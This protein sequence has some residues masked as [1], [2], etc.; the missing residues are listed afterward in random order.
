LSS[1]LAILRMKNYLSE[2]IGIIALVDFSQRSKQLYGRLRELIR[3]INSTEFLLIV[4]HADRNTP[5]DLALKKFFKDFRSKNIKLV[6]VIPKY[7]E[8]EL[9]RLRNE[10]MRVADVKVVLLV[11]VDIFP[12]LKLFRSLASSVFAGERLS[13]APCIYLSPLGN[14]I[15]DRPGG[16]LKVV[17]SALSF[18]PDFVMHWAI[19]SSVMAFRHDDYWS[20]GGFYEK[21]RGHG[22]EDF[23]FMLRLA[24][25]IN[26]IQP[27]SDLLI[28]RTYR[29]PLLS[30]GFRAVLGRLCLPNLLC[31]NIAV[32]LHHEKDP[33]SSYQL[34]R[35][36]NSN[37]F[38]NRIRKLNG[39][40]IS[41][42]PIRG[43]QNLIIDF[44]AECDKHG[45]DP[46]RFHVL[47]DS[48][49]RH[50]LIRRPWWSR[51]TRSLSR[52]FS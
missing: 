31:G 21:F 9:A 50:L 38:Q 34:R 47:F 14:K 52:F 41:N 20:V 39:P 16:I 42:A 30:T 27:S 15:I 22:Y 23:D 13:M 17:E 1:Y 24:M 3:V 29:A 18:S 25:H 32:H 8:A 26:L 46:E 33:L 6:S 37:I 7:E 36:S 11:D 28:D 10:A 2:S 40:N 43:A 4:A 51:A 48:R 44:F 5:Y 12:D 49:P 19:P 35:S 45:I